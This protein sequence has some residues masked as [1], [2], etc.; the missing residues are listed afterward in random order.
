MRNSDIVE[1]TGADP[2]EV[3]DILRA[4]SKRGTLRKDPDGPSRGKNVRWLP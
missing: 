2:R 4:L 3:S 1:A